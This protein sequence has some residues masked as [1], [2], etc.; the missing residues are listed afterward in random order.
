MQTIYLISGKYPKCIRN[1]YSSIAKNKTKHTQNK[2]T[3][4]NPILK[5][6]KESISRFSK[7]TQ[8]ANNYMTRWSKSLIIREM[9]IKTTMRY[10]LITVRMPIIKI[11]TKG[12]CW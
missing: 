5:R 8:V 1:S 12:K 3:K 4:I 6:S 11:K 7:D 2:K 10:D 9:Q